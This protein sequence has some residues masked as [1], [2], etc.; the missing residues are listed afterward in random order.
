MGAAAKRTRWSPQC[1]ASVEGDEARF[2]LWAPQSRKV[3]LLQRIGRAQRRLRMVADGEFHRVS[4][5][6]ESVSAYQYVLDGV[7]VRPDPASLF[8]PEGVHGPSQVVDV[9]GFPWHDRGWEG[10]A[11]EDLVIYELHVGTCSPAGTFDSLAPMLRQLKEGL[12]VTAV[13]LMPIAQFPGTRN[14][15]Y[16]GVFPYAVQNSYGGPAAF[17]R[18]VDRCHQAGLA[19]LLDVVYNHLG[20]EGNYLRGFGP[21][22]SAKYTTP[23][24]EALNYDGPGS[25]QVRRF[26]LDNAIHWIRSF[27]VDGLRLDAVHGIFDSSPKHILQELA[28][29]AR[30]VERDLGRRVL[31]VAESDLNDPKL[32]K[33]V[34]D[35]GYG[36]DGQWAD[37]MHHALHSYLTGESFGYYQDFGGLGDVAKA[38]VEPFVYDGRY[39]A[40]RRKRH[41]ESSKGVP[42]RRFVVFSQNHDQVGNRAD[43]ARLSTI[44]GMAKAKVAAAAVLLSPYLPLL[45]M[46]EEYGEKAPFYFFT[47]Y[48]D[49]LVAEA[50]RAGRRRETSDQGAEFVDPQAPATFVSSK[51]DRRLASRAEGK[52]MLAYYSGLARLRREHPAVKSARANTEVREFPE[53]TALAVRRWSKDEAL[54]L[55]FVLGERRIELGGLVREGRWSLEFSSSPGSPKVLGPGRSSFPGP[56]A[57]VYRKTLPRDRS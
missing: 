36:L 28:E 46:G 39:S 32:V 16:D 27:H 1:G 42:G 5:P 2:C 4:V 22:F 48:G 49:S 8:Q 3:E 50:T 25:D 44:A 20:P 38:F 29:E 11:L 55:L 13:E 40:Y 26:V 54:L 30:M 35:C 57:S 17:A 47:D 10:V 53:E 24:G 37:D 51:L 23:W 43:G 19:V 41:G 56:S 9:G 34:E 15:G 6:R 45:F 18:L 7:D 33:R 14:W 52:R 12:G 21:Y 31:V